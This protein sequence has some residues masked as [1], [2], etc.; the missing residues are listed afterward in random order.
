[1]GLDVSGD[2]FDITA[3]FEPG[4]AEVLG[5]D[6]GGN[7]I[8]Y[9]ADAGRLEYHLPGRLQEAP[10]RPVGGKVTIRVLLDRPIVEINGNHGRVVITSP[11]AQKGEVRT[12]EAFATGGTARLV[13]VEVNELESILS[14]SRWPR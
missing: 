8:E 7:R 14:I 4:D 11:R 3:I 13:E 12:V 9:R 10:L 5:L 6:I 1:M 2:I